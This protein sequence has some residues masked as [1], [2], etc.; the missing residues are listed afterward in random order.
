MGATGTV[1]HVDDD[2]VYAFGHPFLSLGTT[3]LA[4]TRSHVYTVLPSL[5][6]SMKIA[7]LGPVI[8]IMGQD[9]STA[10]G[11]RLGAGPPELKISIALS[12][13]RAGNRDFTYYA[14]HD[15]QLTPL[16]AFVAILN[17]L[18]S[19]E[20]QNGELSIAAGGSV[21]FADGGRIVLDDF[22]TGPGAL[23]AAAGGLTAAIGAATTNGFRTV[24][25]TSL[26]L[27][28]RA[29]EGDDWTTIERVWLDTVKPRAG[30]TYAL[31]VELRRHRGALETLAF[32]V[33]MPQ[34]VTG[35][36]TI[37]VSDGP[38]LTT[39]ERQELRPGR[40]TSWP[41]LFAELQAA[42]SNNRVYVRLVTTSAGTVVSGETLPALPQSVRSALEADRTS[43]QSPVARSVIGEWER[44]MDR[45]VRGSREITVTL[46]PRN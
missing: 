40:P 23:G 29:S 46:G 41:A 44:R 14:L 34:K 32:P 43:A 38:S 16:F 5:D 18:V 39:L 13:A 10:V 30:G 31:N 33:T 27:E 20:R 28:L 21:T 4:M 6:T 15:P 8:G 26:D 1:T 36:V 35:P 7:S 9:R 19:Y 11:G 12:S 45:A 3:Q 22:F 2:R 25:P 42:R 24:M 17:T 37:I